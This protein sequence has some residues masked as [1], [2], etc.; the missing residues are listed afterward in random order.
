[1]CILLI[2]NN[3][4]DD[5]PLIIAANRDE[6]H[7]RPTHHAQ[8]WS[9]HPSIYGGRD[10]VA[11]GTWFGLADHGNLAAITNIRAPQTTL[12]NKRSR[13][14]LVVK[15]L[16]Y[17]GSHKHFHENLSTTRGHYEGY[18]LLFGNWKNLSV[19]NNHNDTVQHLS[20]GFYGLSNDALNT[21][22][23]KVTSGLI[24][25]EQ[26]VMERDVITPFD[27][28]DILHNTKR[29]ED[30]ELPDTGVPYLWEKRLSSIFISGEE[31]GTRCSTV[32]LVNKHGE[33]Q[34]VEYSYGPGGEYTGEREANF[35][36]SL[37]R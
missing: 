23:P 35:T 9:D 13:G 18:N 6:F 12:S 7:H 8:R 19:Y 21:P 22:W 10:L 36:F 3:V 34:F 37:V 1:M 16:T 30:N 31:Y 2:A 28:L 17:E 14:E 4:R 24:A 5:Y 29:A 15:Y 26:K 27:F 33:A 32:L 20:N 25:L 11:G